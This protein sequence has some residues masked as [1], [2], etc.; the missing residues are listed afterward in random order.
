MF[1]LDVAPTSGYR[2]RQDTGHD[3]RL[4]RPDALLLGGYVRP[5][6]RLLR[7]TSELRIS[8]IATV[9]SGR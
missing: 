1:D 9:I 8:S 2:G 5:V 7:R 4:R 3:C 6:R